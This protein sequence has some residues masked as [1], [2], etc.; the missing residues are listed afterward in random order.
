MESEAESETSVQVQND[1]YTVRNLGERNVPKYG[2]TAQ[3]WGLEFH[4]VPNTD[5]D[6]LLHNAFTDVIDQAF[7][8]ADPQDLVGLQLDSSKLERGYIL[9]PFCPRLEMTSERLLRLISSV[10]QSNKSMK[11]SDIT[12]LDC[13]RVKDPFR[14]GVAIKRNPARKYLQ[15]MRNTDNLCL[16]RTIAIS[17][18]K[19]SA[20]AKK[21]R[22]IIRSEKIQRAAA[23]NIM[24]GA[25]LGE[26]TR[27]TGIDQLEQ[28][29]CSLY[30]NYQLI[31]YDKN[32]VQ[33]FCE[34][35][36]RQ[37]IYLH[38][39]NEHYSIIRSM[40]SFFGVNYWCSACRKGYDK[41]ETHRLVSY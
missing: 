19:L 15:E 40:K 31:V 5:L 32:R 3:A 35:P 24:E 25:G 6:Q 17:K 16:A 28:I 12:Q 29:Q 4:D 8:D 26:Y 21:Y 20:D 11:L 13:V 30:P 14:G 7:K 39:E 18:V 1:E 37:Q 38:I 9:L 36:S 27:M 41:R 22:S 2:I 33:M 34:N 23:I 10:L